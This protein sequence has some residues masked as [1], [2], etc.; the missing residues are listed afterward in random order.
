MKAGS[1]ENALF[2]A[3]LIVKIKRGA[4]T[5]FEVLIAVAILTI[6]SAVLLPTL[7]TARER[8]RRITCL[9]NER[10]I[11]MA[12]MS[13]AAD[14]NGYL[15]TQA[16]TASPY[17]D[18]SARLTNYM[19]GSWSPSNPNP[20]CVFTCAGDRNER[21]AVAQKRFWRSY[22][23]NGTNQWSVG[24]NVPW[25]SSEETPMKLGQIPARVILIGE[26]HG[27][28]GGT[29]P[30]SSGA[31]VEHSEMENLQGHASAMHRETGLSGVASTT[32]ANGGGNYSYP[33]GRVEFHPRSELMNE[34]HVGSFNG[35]VNDPWKWQ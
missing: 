29:V 23:V 15:P 7:H 12:M 13:Y 16:M 5:L 22:A 6:L 20:R 31:Y 26:N 32:D 30:G 2:L 14:N 3:C 24:F 19:D 25:P 10:Q 35:G 27:I 4:F 18:W 1:Q 17:T 28:D 9:S 34:T 11:L 8:S 33:D 21:R